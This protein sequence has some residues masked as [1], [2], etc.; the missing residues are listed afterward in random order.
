MRWPKINITVDEQNVLIK[1]KK[2][3]VIIV[4]VLLAW[5]LIVIGWQIYVLI[6]R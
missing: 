3:A 6:K 4:R 5:C 2:S 1:Q